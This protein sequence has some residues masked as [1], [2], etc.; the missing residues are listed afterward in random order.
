MSDKEAQYQ[1]LNLKKFL[2]FSNFGKLDRNLPLVRCPLIG[3]LA[4]Q[5][6]CNYEEFS[7]FLYLPYCWRNVLVCG[8]VLFKI[9]YHELGNIDRKILEFLV[10]WFFLI[11]VYLF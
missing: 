5:R 4:L 11:K 10:F 1:N 2:F 6:V 9:G 7:V 3:I 8:R